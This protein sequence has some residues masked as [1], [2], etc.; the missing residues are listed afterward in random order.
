MTL[1]TWV[2]ANFGVVQQIPSVEAVRCWASYCLRREVTT[3]EL[4]SAFATVAD[5]RYPRTPAEAEAWRCRVR[6]DVPSAED[7]RHE[8]RPKRSQRGQLQRRTA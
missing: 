5:E 2:Q 4:G 6:E 7:M 3:E 8:R 1:L